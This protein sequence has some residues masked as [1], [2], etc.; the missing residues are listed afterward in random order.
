MA[1]RLSAR[2][3]SGLSSRWRSISCRAWQ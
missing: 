3:S 2:A 1:L